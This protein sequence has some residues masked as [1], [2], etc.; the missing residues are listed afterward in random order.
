[1]AEFWDGKILLVM[2]DDPKYAIKK[3][4]NRFFSSEQAVELVSQFLCAVCRHLKIVY[5]VFS[6]LQVY[7]LAC[8]AWFSCLLSHNAFVRALY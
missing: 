3:V 2:P 5:Y 6:I 8:P 1:M 7:R 4:H